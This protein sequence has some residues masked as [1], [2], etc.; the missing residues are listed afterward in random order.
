MP[1]VPLGTDA[2]S[3]H[4]SVG[5]LASASGG[6]TI[7]ECSF[8]LGISSATSSATLTAMGLLVSGE[9]PGL[10]VRRNAFL[11]AQEGHSGP[12][13]RSVFGVVA[14]AS[15]SIITTSLNNAEISDNVFLRWGA[16]VVTF[17]QLGLLRCTNNRVSECGI[18]LFFAD[19]NLGATGELARQALAD[20]V[21]SGQNAATALALNTS[22]QAPMLAGIANGMAPF[23]AKAPQPSTPPVISETARNVLLQDITNRGTAAWRALALP[24]DTPSTGTPIAQGLSDTLV[25]SLDVVREISLAAAAAGAAL[26]PILHI[27]GNDVGLAS[28][29]L[30]LADGS[31][32]LPGIGIAVVL[33][34]RD[35]SGTVLLTANRVLTADPQTRAAALLYPAAAAVTG[36]VLMQTGA[37]AQGS[38]P[39]FLLF[40]EQGAAFEVMA[41]VI[42]ANALIHPLARSTSAPTTSWN[43]LNTTS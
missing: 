41:N 37:Q 12:V 19:S 16:A 36:N 23:A 8:R 17:S 34:P 1:V 24:P 25:K 4:L 2:T 18:G 14:S 11:A 28:A 10:T 21:Q 33:S 13:G 9:S 5:I 39:A 20:G 15:S 26:A 42:V 35:E 32:A 31:P 38:V 30:V 43:F 27:S 22:M 40:A 7:E 6:A 3:A 29:G